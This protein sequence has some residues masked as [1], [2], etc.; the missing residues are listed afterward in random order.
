MDNIHL[1]INAFYDYRVL[2]C[3]LELNSVKINK[4]KKYNMV[5]ISYLIKQI[6]I[7]KPSGELLKVLLKIF[8]LR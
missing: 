6:M 3:V 4:F 5:L 7:C 1:V 2:I 8:Y